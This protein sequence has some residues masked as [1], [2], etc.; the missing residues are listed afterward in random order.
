MIDMTAI[1]TLYASILFVFFFSLFFCFFLFCE[2]REKKNKRINVRYHHYLRISVIV[3]VN[4]NENFQKLLKFWWVKYFVDSFNSFP[5]SSNIHT[6]I[7]GT[8]LPLVLVCVLV[9]LWDLLL[10]QLSVGLKW[11][12]LHYDGISYIPH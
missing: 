6:G 8:G 1:R 2:L 4:H 12:D 11:F 3:I 9:L 7:N 5:S 10:V